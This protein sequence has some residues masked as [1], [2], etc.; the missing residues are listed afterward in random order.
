M[1]TPSQTPQLVAILGAESTGKT[2][3]A[4]ALAHKFNCPWVAEYL[5]DFCAEEN[6]TPRIEEQHGIMKR[7]IARE[8]EALAFATTNQAPYV[9]CDTAPIQTAIYSDYVF[10]DESLYD[11]AK[12]LHARYAVTLILAPDIDWVADGLQRE[13][14]HVR[15][16][17]HALI[18]Q[19]LGEIGTT[20]ILIEGQGEIRAIN[21]VS[22]L[23]NLPAKPTRLPIANSGKL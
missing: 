23:A 4:K 22:A 2:T 5:R 12:A 11:E 17:I 20:A 18:M 7:Q 9:F 14:A 6:R 15:D 13:G 1:P 16:D 8:G 19:N 21:A 10:S 3:L